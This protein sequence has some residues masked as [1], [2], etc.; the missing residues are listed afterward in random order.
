MA[1]GQDVATWWQGPRTVWPLAVLHRAPFL[2]GS[3]RLYAMREL[4]RRVNCWVPMYD[5]G[6]EMLTDVVR[7]HGGAATR[8]AVLDS[9]VFYPVSWNR[10]HEA[11]SARWNTTVFGVDA[12]RRRFNRSYAATF[13]THTWSIGCVNGRKC[14]WKTG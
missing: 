9:N 5:T 3:R 6:P 4:L 11:H 8:A 7:E 2:N 1:E 14:E 12:M 10:M 13:W